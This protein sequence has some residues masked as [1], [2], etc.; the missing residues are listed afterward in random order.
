MVGRIFWKHSFVLSTLKS[1]YPPPL[2]WIL[3]PRW[4]WDGRKR[5]KDGSSLGDHLVGTVPIST[6]PATA[7]STP[8]PPAELLCVGNTT[9]TSE[10][11]G[12]KKENTPNKAG[13][14]GQPQETKISLL[15]P[16]RTHVA[17]REETGKVE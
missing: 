7:E 3:P 1:I 6:P 8:P 13:G 17:D 12:T 15:C 2:K 9:I 5:L 11:Q 4:P 10:T 14:G 16:K